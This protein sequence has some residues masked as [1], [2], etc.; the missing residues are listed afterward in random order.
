M[1]Y[2]ND[3][4]DFKLH[5]FVPVFNRSKV[6]KKFIENVL[7][8]TF[9]NFALYIIDDKSSD[10]T[11]LIVKKYADID[12]RV[13]LIKTKGNEWW[14]GSIAFGLKKIYDQDI[15][16]SN[17][18]IAF[19]NDDVFIKKNLINDLLKVSKQYSESIISPVRVKNK[20]IISSGSKII[21]WPLALSIRPL[22]GK[23]FSINK[24]QSLAEIDFIGANCTVFPSIL[25]KKIGYPN[26]KKLPHY[27]ADGEYF[28]SAK[29]YNYKIYLCPFLEIKRD[30]SLTGLFNSDNQSKISDFIKSFYH[31]KSINN[32]GDRINFAKLCCP[33]KYLFPYLFITLIYSFIRSLFIILKNYF[34]K[35]VKKI[36]Y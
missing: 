8:Q 17:D 14:A 5:I 29:K 12:K 27:H 4:L 35:F 26:F 22:K 25:I 3:K 1:N 33:K 19:M 16:K 10:D 31:R 23:S 34:R 15:I 24:L 11:P 9:E 18:Y 21:N 30:D 2:K 36:I 7:Q 20:K 28:Y 6:T 32:V 13:N